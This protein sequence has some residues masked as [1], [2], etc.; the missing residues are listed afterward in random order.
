MEPIIEEVIY[1]GPGFYKNEDGVLLYAPNFVSNLYYELNI[2]EKDSYEYPVDGWYY[3]D[4][5]EEA[6]SN[7]NL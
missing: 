2:Q 5:E 4:S 3:Y 6:I 7:N 1:R